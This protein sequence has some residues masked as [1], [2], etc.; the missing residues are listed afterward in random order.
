MGGRAAE[1]FQSV[2]I[3]DN[4]AETGKALTINFLT[5]TEKAPDMPP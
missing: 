2:K 4:A 1:Y 3:K 5:E